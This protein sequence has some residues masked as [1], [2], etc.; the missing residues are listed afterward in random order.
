MRDEILKKL[1]EEINMKKYDFRKALAKEKPEEQANE[2]LKRFIETISNQE[3]RKIPENDMLEFRLLKE[4]W[5]SYDVYRVTCDN[6]A[7]ERLD[8][9][10]IEEA[11]EIF[12]SILK[13]LQEDS[14]SI[15]V[16]WDDC[17]AIML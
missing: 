1:R 17:F 4:S 5:L 10:S 15:A 9:E 7:W 14:Y 13:L 2:I 11:R 3:R 16:F 8:C 6:L 12:L